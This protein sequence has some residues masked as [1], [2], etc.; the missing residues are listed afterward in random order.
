M[1]TPEVK[2]CQNPVS[3][4]CSQAQLRLPFPHPFLSSEVRSPASIIWFWSSS[5]PGSHLRQ[6]HPPSLELPSG[7]WLLSATVVVIHLRLPPLCLPPPGP[8]TTETVTGET[9]AALHSLRTS[10]EGTKDQEMETHEFIYSTDIYEGIP[11]SQPP[12]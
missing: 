3:T 12:F 6:A 2:K 9:G 4:R 10:A 11:V 1:K 8:R 7:V 5:L